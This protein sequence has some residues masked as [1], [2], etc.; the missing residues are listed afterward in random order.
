MK[1]RERQK[2]EKWFPRMR[3]YSIRYLIGTG[4]AAVVV[5]FCVGWLVYDGVAPVD[6]AVDNDILTVGQCIDANATID[7][8]EETLIEEGIIEEN[9]L[10]TKVTNGM[11]KD[12]LEQITDGTPVRRLV[13]AQNYMQEIKLIEQAMREAAGEAAT[14]GTD[15]HP[16]SDEFLILFR[17]IAQ[18]SEQVPALAQYD[19]TGGDGT[20]GVKPSTRQAAAA[21]NAGE[22]GD[23]SIPER[24][25]QKE[26]ALN[27]AGASVPEAK[28]GARCSL[29]ENL[30]GDIFSEEL[31]RRKLAQV[32]P[33]PAPKEMR[34]EGTVT[35]ELLVS[36]SVREVYE[37][38]ERLY[39]KVAQ[40]SEAK[41]CLDLTKI[42]KAKLT[43]SPGSHVEIST[44][45]DSPF[46]QRITH[47]TTWR[48]DVTANT[49]GD[50]HLFLFLG[51]DVDK[52]SGARTYSTWVDPAPLRYDEVITVIKARP[53]QQVLDSAGRNW[54]WLLPLGIALLTVVAALLVRVL[55]KD[56]QRRPGGP[57]DEPG[58]D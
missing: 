4:A 6:A 31:S 48:W 19:G 14:R 15:W 38:L 51:Q 55:M 47:N 7:P 41:D 5:A 11:C 35:V 9:L 50:Y 54:W 56:E 30:L 32:R 33:D 26:D 39:E 20:G 2:E 17:T 27:K 13:A 36:G 22:D 23:A 49:A 1:P 40:V 53:L 43:G 45:E 34:Y 21:A 3:L 42:M 18:T 10:Q 8:L 29:E 44:H 28:A 12:M 57:R 24:L 37:K 25:R 16:S 58:R 46:K 52:F